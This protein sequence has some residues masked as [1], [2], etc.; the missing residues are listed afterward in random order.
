MKEDAQMDKCK[1][2][3]HI[4]G[5]MDVLKKYITLFFQYN[6]CKRKWFVRH[7]SS[8]RVKPPFQVSLESIEFKQGLNKNLI[9]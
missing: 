9:E 3:N 1:H 8:Y 6:T 5:I 4:S 7:L 2:K